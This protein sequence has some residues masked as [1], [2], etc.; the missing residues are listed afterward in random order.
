MLSLSNTPPC[1]QMLV[2]NSVHVMMA[3]QRWLLILLLRKDIALK[4]LKRIGVD[5]FF[6]HDKLNE[7]NTLLSRKHGDKVEDILQRESKEKA[8]QIHEKSVV[9]TDYVGEK[10][11]ANTKNIKKDVFLQN[12]LDRI[13][14]KSSLSLPIFFFIMMVIFFLSVNIG[15]FLQELLDIVTKF[16]CVDLSKYLLIK[17]HADGPLQSLLVEGVGQGVSLVISFIPMLYIFY[18]LV[19]LLEDSGYLIRISILLDKVM[20]M[21]GIPGQALI[22]FIIGFGCNVPAILGTRGIK[23]AVSQN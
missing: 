16:V 9:C 21:L 12:K 8:S 6:T 1:K 17:C 7:Y 15:G 20:R 19:I 13:F 3:R 22:S 10:S 14:L 4:D 23:I 2:D 5:T 11:N 18:L